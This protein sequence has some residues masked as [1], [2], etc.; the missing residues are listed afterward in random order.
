MPVAAQTASEGC[1]KAAFGL[2]QPI[3]EIVV[4]TVLTMLTRRPA[5]GVA[6][7]AISKGLALVSTFSHP[8]GA[9]V[10]G[11]HLHWT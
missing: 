2:A 5:K 4:F 9:T 10:G 8:V 11:V 6:S 3:F 7:A 1:K